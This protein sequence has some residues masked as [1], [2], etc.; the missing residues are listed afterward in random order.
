MLLTADVGNTNIKLGLFDDDKLKF[1]LRFA[2]DKS[3]TADDFAVELYTFFQIYGIDSSSIDS[4]IIASV[5][6]QITYPLKSAIFTVTGIKSMVVG[7]GIKTG[8]DLKIDHPETLGADMVAGCVGVGKKYGFPSMVIFMGTAT[9]TVFVDEN[10]MYRGGSIF[11]GVGISLDALTSRGALLSSVDMKAPKKVISTNTTDCI[12]S[13]I[14][15]GTACM[16]DGMLDKFAQES[17]CKCKIIATGG[18]ASQIIQNCSHDIIYDENV[19]LD[20]LNIIY[21]KN[22]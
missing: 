4:S 2:T 7:P 17:G 21:K 14:V 16:I 5:V 20:G 9:A 13:G 22:I 11:P 12:R 15:F 6:P 8:L 1:R 10:K 19:I 3:K 18:L